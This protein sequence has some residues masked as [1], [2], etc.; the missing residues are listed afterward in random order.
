MFLYPLMGMGF[1]IFLC[2]KERKD[3]KS[4]YRSKWYN[5]LFK[6]LLCIALWPW[7]VPFMIYED[8]YNIKKRIKKFKAS[9]KE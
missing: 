3:F 9:I 4:S 8:W 1:V 7:L 6:A 5:L 2:I